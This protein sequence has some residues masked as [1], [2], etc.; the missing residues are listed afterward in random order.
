MINGDTKGRG[1][2]QALGKALAYQ[3]TKEQSAKGGGTEDF[4]A[5][6][7]K[8]SPHLTLLMNLSPFDTDSKDQG[9]LRDSKPRISWDLERQCHS[10]WASGCYQNPVSSFQD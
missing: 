3:M 10:G 6:H 1:G 4:R 5:A 8:G 9:Y 7:C 2:G